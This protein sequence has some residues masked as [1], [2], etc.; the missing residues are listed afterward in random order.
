[1]LKYQGETMILHIK[2]RLKKSGI[3]VTAIILAGILITYLDILIVICQKVFIDRVLDADQYKWLSFII[4]FV[5]ILV[6]IQSVVSMISVY[7]TYCL[8]GKIQTVS[9]VSFLYKMMQLPVSYFEKNRDGDLLE[10]Y[11]A[12]EDIVEKIITDLLPM[13]V[14]ILMGLLYLYSMLHLHRNLTFFCLAFFAVNSFLSRKLYKKIREYVRLELEY[15]GELQGYTV[16]GL[17]N[18]LQIKSV[19]AERFYFHKWCGYQQKVQSVAEKNLNQTIM[20][21]SVIGLIDRLMQTGIVLTGALYIMDNEITLGIFTAFQVLLVNIVTPIDQLRNSGQILQKS[22]EQIH[23]VQHVFEE[24]S[25]ELIRKQRQVPLD[26]DVQK[27]KGH[28]EIKNVTFRYEKQS[29][30][31][32][33]QVSLDIEP[34]KCI[35]IV[36]ASGS[37]KSTII[38][39]LSGLYEPEQGQILYDGIPIQ[40][41]DRSRFTRSIGIVDQQILLFHDTIEHNITLWDESI[42]K[43]EMI[44]AAT[45]AEIH[46]EIVGKENGYQTILVEN[47]ANLSGGQRQRIEI[48]RALAKRP[49]IL[50][51]D[52]VTSSLDSETE[53][54]VMEKIRNRGVTTFI[55]AHRLSTIREC[56]EILVMRGGRI[57]TRGSHHRLMEQSKEYQ[58][59]V[60][61]Q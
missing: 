2:E 33:E 14:N 58:Q 45:D 5:M 42:G 54:N 36:G 13:L 30:P 37:G 24:E 52:E 41:I 57:V 23:R 60:N 51:L 16:E 3:P 25:D 40:C 44:L 32:V 29:A 11:K 59:L 56:D 10:Q 9:T 19:G 49:T 12:N 8:K 38:K 48:A 20:Y 46:T 28:I 1:M 31:S 27:L 4:I 61:N 17:R 47:G 26:D 21:L 53:K 15:K 50:L 34:G 39:L 6:L 18:M 7:Y 22:A 43:Y 35:G 55:V